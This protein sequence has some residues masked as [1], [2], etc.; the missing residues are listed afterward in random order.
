MAKWILDGNM[1]SDFY[2]DSIAKMLT[3]RPENGVTS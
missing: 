2:G 3:A 1:N